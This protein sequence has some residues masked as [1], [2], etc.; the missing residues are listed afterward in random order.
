MFSCSKRCGTVNG[1][2]FRFV[3]EALPDGRVV[4]IVEELSEFPSIRPSPPVT[5]PG[6][7]VRPRP[8]IAIPQPPTLPDTNSSTW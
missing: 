7:P 6:F 5:V 8:P 3:T 4:T 2:R 1:E